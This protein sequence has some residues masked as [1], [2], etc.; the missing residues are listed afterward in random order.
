MCI[1]NFFLVC[2]VKVDFGFFVDV[3]GSIEMY[4]CG[5]YQ[6]MK[7]F[8]KEV[9]GSFVVFRYGIYVG[10]VVFVSR[11]ELVFQFNIYYMR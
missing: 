7:D 6:C 10:L 9:V 5:N 1:F 8:I 4:G 3:F 2:K 11:F